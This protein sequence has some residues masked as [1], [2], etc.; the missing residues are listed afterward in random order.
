MSDLLSRR[1]MLQATVSSLY[2]GSI[3]KILAQVRNA[4]GPRRP[5]PAQFQ[6]GDLLWPKPPDS[7]VPFRSSIQLS[8]EIQ[9][10]AQW[11]KEKADY[12]AML[13]SKRELTPVEQERYRS[14]QRMTYDEFKRLYLGDVPPDE[15]IPKSLIPVFYVGHVAM[16]R[17]D[18]GS[19]EVIEALDDKNVRRVG[20]EDWLRERSTADIWHGRLIDIGDFVGEKVAEQAL[21][22]VGKPYDFW[23]FDLD[24]ESGFYCSKLIWL[25]VAK[26]SGRSLDDNSNP[27]RLWWY[28]PKRCMHSPH[29]RMMFKPGDY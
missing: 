28:S 24:D 23:N 20:Y 19:R 29:V 18:G 5:D 15:P 14:L 9:D 21:R 2:L 27:K 12:L 13:R 3:G 7:F 1:R 4:A 16:V 26:V 10:R 25:S 11:E 8:T 6:S 22:F 17:V